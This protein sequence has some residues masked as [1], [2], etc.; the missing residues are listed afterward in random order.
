[1]R[2]RW[3]HGSSAAE[4]SVIVARRLDTQLAAASERAGVAV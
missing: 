1:M 4:N 2:V 3:L